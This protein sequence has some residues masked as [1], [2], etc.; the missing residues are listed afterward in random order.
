MFTYVAKCQYPGHESFY[1]YTQE[2]VVQN[3]NDVQDTL[4][5]EVRR[6]WKKISPHT[7]PEIVEIKVGLLT[8]TRYELYE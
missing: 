2:M 4:R 8:L 6:Q 7:P 3:I 1:F 5:E